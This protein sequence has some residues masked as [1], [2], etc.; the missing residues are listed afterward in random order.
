MKHYEKL[1]AKGY[2]SREQLTELVGTAMLCD[3]LCSGLPLY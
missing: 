2:F 3:R 1:L